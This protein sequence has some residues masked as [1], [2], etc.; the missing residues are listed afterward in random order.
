MFCVETCVVHAGVEPAA[1]AITDTAYSPAPRPENVPD[2]CGPVTPPP[3]FAIMYLYVRDAASACVPPA[4][5]DT[6]ITPSVD[7]L[8]EMSVFAVVAVTVLGR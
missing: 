1:S 3:T 8:Q 4:V 5:F 6:V 2:D 7:V